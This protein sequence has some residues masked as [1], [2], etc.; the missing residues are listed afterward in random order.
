M[1]KFLISAVVC[2][3]FVASCGAFHTKQPVDDTYYKNTQSIAWPE[4]QT[5][6]AVAKTTSVPSGNGRAGVTKPYEVEAEIEKPKVAVP[7]AIESKFECKRNSSGDF[8]C[9]YGLNQCGEHCKANGSNCRYGNCLQSDCDNVM[10]QKWELIQEN[11]LYYACKHPSYPIVCR[12]FGNDGYKCF[13]NGYECGNKCNANGT[14][15]RSG[16][17]NCW[18]E[19]R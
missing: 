15:C 17:N 9:S 11:S 7:D 18:D 3:M 14:L 4:Q 16:H 2:S 1:K 8:T 6:T 19:Y 5:T 13:N 10:G 12:K